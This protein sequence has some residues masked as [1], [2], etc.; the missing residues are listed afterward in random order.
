[1]V[2]KKVNI[3]S[4]KLKQFL[5]MHEH[6]ISYLTTLLIFKAISEPETWIKQLILFIISTK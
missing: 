1:M 4:D 2:L 5:Y 6:M 3:V